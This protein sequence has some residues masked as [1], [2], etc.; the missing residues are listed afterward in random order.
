M[1]GEDETSFFQKGWV[2][3]QQIAALKG[4]LPPLQQSSYDGQRF[5]KKI[6]HQDHLH[7]LY[8]LTLF[9][10]NHLIIVY[11]RQPFTI[12]VY[13]PQPCQGGPPRM[14]R[15]PAPAVLDEEERGEFHTSL[16][17]WL[18]VQNWGW[19]SGVQKP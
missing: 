2:C 15:P 8:Y 17:M 13:Q 5:G 12:N 16:V 3:N 11:T 6:V 7:I 4:P 10:I 14:K 9:Y 19:K 18:N 1:E